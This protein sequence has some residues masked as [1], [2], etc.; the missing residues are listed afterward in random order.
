MGPYQTCLCSHTLTQGQNVHSHS[1]TY[2]C[3]MDNTPTSFQHTREISQWRMESQSSRS[4]HY[5]DFTYN[6]TNQHAAF[7][8]W[9]LR[10]LWRHS[11][12][13]PAL[14]CAHILPILVWQAGC[15]MAQFIWVKVETRSWNLFLSPI[16]GGGL[17]FPRLSA[18]FLQSSLGSCDLRKED[19]ARVQAAHI[20]NVAYIRSSSGDV[21][22]ASMK[23]SLGR[24]D[25]QELYL[26]LN[27]VKEC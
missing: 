2:W 9:L 15:A 20:V 8:S 23:E 16:K 21:I 10:G 7:F 11:S 5:P 25:D 19:F 26:E 4:R 24:P 12:G 13:C 18:L 17:W 14:L 27:P 22:L 3:W 6:W 1:K